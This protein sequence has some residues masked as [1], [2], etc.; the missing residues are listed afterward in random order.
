V[1]R[2]VENIRTLHDALEV[3]KG[4]IKRLRYGPNQRLFL[5][6]EDKRKQNEEQP[7]LFHLVKKW[8]WQQARHIGLVRNDEGNECASARE[9]LRTF[10]EHLRRKDYTIPLDKQ[11]IHDM[12]EGV[13]MKLATAA[14]TAFQMPI[15]EEKLH[16]AVMSGKKKKAPGY[17]G[18]CTDFLQVAWPTIGEDLL[19][20]VNSVY[21]DGDVA[22]TQTKG[23][24][25]FVP[26][27]K[28]PTTPGEYRPLTL[29]NS[30][31]KLFSRILVNRMRP[32]LDDILHSNQH[33]GYRRII[34]WTQ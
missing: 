29:L 20:I 15:T 18:I 14:H 12:L 11:A 1:I 22:P 6:A 9:M 30:D 33:M 7:T 28:S 13:K 5:G 16:G 2:D 3:L 4:K 24:I 17:D 31:I 19:Q 32:W 26:K 10:T 25:V 8:K 34:Y 23:V 27:S 21:T